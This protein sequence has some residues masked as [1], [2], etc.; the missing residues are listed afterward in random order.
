MIT[1][2]T[3]ID[4]KVGRIDRARCPIDAIDRP[5]DG[6]DG[7]KGAPGP[8]RLPAIFFAGRATGGVVF[9]MPGRGV[10]AAS[11]VRLPTPLQRA[12]T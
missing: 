11:T 12:Q 10:A 2:D 9:A 3:P 8:Y 6:R 5:N 7:P 4:A 1:I